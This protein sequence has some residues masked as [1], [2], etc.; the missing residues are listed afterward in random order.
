MLSSLAVPNPVADIQHRTVTHAL[1]NQPE[2]TISLQEQHSKAQGATTSSGVY[3]LVELR[4]KLEQRMEYSTKVHSYGPDPRMEPD[5]SIPS[6]A[7][8]TGKIMIDNPNP[9]LEQNQL[10]SFTSRE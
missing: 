4:K 3:D 7:S 6:Y 10:N 8:S 9:I 2:Q 1:L 5:E